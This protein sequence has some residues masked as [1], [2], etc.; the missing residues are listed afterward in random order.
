MITLT[1]RNLLLFHLSLRHPLKIELSFK[2]STI[3]VSC[4]RNVVELLLFHFC[5]E[6]VLNIELNFKDQLYFSCEQNVVE[7]WLFYDLSSGHPVKIEP[8]RE[9]QPY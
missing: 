4:E 7:L 6:H 3:F 5:L 2:L 1:K 9:G 8:R